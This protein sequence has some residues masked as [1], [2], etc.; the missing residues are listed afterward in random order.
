MIMLAWFFMSPIIYPIEMV[1]SVDG[2]LPWWVSLAYFLNPMTGIISAYR[3][4]LIGAPNPGTELMNLSFVVAIVIGL[5]GVWIFKKLEDGF[6]D[7]L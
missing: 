4:T 1:T 5:V 3:I 7:E 2:G 6:G